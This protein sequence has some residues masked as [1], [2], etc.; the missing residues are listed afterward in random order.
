MK[1]TTCLLIFVS[2]LATSCSGKYASVEEAIITREG[3]TGQ[4]KS[5]PIVE[6]PATERPNVL[7]TLK[8]QEFPEHELHTCLGARAMKDLI[9]G[10]PAN[11]CLHIY[12]S[13][14]WLKNLSEPTDDSLNE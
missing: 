8:E 5:I 10:Y 4:E 9:D 11:F 13:K 12:K 1:Q 7:R 14:G 6:P 3:L 2:L